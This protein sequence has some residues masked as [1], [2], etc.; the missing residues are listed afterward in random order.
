VSF[1]VDP[2]EVVVETGT[3]SWIPARG[4]GVG[5]V[6][7][8]RLPGELAVA[9]LARGMGLERVPPVGGIAPYVLDVDVEL[10]ASERLE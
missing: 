6:S 5:E 7:A 9:G 1:V 10:G 8:G 3:V 4:A 2:D